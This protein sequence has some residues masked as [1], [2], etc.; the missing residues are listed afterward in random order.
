MLAPMANWRSAGNVSRSRVR[1]SK[2]QE[3]PRLHL[4]MAVARRAADGESIRSWNDASTRARRYK[5]MRRLWLGKSYDKRMPRPKTHCEG[6]YP[7]LLT[8]GLSAQ[9]HTAMTHFGRESSRNETECWSMTDFAT[10]FQMPPRR[11]QMLFCCGVFATVAP[12]EIG[13]AS[14]SSRNDPSNSPPPSMSGEDGKPAQL[15]DPWV[16][17]F[18]RMSGRRE[19]SSEVDP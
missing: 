5:E 13:I 15:H 6:L 7:F 11:S 3:R 14:H 4:D 8:Q 2:A 12:T 17:V 10:P 16:K 1:A 18:H 19:A 9:R